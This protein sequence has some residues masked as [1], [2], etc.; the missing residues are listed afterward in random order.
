M[1][2]YLIIIFIMSLITFLLYM[3]DKKRSIKHKWRIKE[4]TL[5]LFSCLFGAFGGIIAMYKYRHKTKHWYFIA[6]NYLAIILQIIL[7]FIIYNK[8]GISIFKAL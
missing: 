7:G 1:I 3:I 6:I 2:E 8:Y 4:F 5:L